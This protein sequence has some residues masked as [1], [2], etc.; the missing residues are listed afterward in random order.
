M[1]AWWIFIPL[2][3]F[4][5]PDLPRRIGGSDP[6]LAAYTL[7]FNIVRPIA[8]GTMLVG[9]ANTMWGMR[10]SLA[11]SLQGAFARF[12]ARRARRAASGERT[13]RDIPASGCCWRSPCCSFPSR[14]ST[15]SS[16]VAGFPPSSPALVMSVTGFCCRRWAVTWWA[17]WAARTSRC[18][19]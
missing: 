13:E 4:F 15:I 10:A 6:S 12:D 1:L 3:L 7:W 11:Q 19:G 16:P 5:D 8:V 9:A 18:R 2:L 14:S 17:W